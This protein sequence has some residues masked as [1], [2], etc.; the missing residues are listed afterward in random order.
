MLT[1]SGAQ[2]P[3]HLIP[4]N[5]N[6]DNNLAG[7]E[8]GHFPNL[9]REHPDNI[10]CST[11]WELRADRAPMPVSM[12]CFGGG[13]AAVSIDPY[14]EG[15]PID[16]PQSDN[17]IRNGLCAQ[18]GTL[19]GS[20]LESADGCGVTLGYGNL[21]VTFLNKDMWRDG[22]HHLSRGASASG[23][24]FLESA[25]SRQAA[26]RVMRTLY[27]VHREQPKTTLNR[28]DA[29]SALTN[30]FLTVNWHD[31]SGR[32][33]NK[34]C[35]LGSSTFF[36]NSPIRENFTNMQRIGQTDRTLRAWR[37][38][39]EIGWTG[40][41]VI[42]TPLLM[43][44][45]KLQNDEAFKH[46]ICA[47]DWVAD[48]YNPTSGLLWDVCGKHEGRRL[49]WW[50]S[51]YLVK[52]VHCAYTNGSA[53][54]HLLKSYEYLKANGG[55]AP[56]AWLDA[57]IKTLETMHRLQL[58]D[59]NFGYTYSPFKPKMIDRNGFAGAWFVPAMALAYRLTGREEFLR[60]AKLGAE[61][62]RGPVRDLHCCGTPMDT[63][64]SPE[65]EGNLGFCHGAMILHEITG[66]DKYLEML[67]ESAEY[68]Y[69]WRYAFRARPEFP[70]LKGSDWNSCG[71]SITSVSNP[72]IH[73]MGIF[74]SKDLKY[75]A[76][77]SGDDYHERRAEDGLLWSLNCIELYPEVSGYGIRG[78]LTERFC[79]SDGL[80]IE[81]L[82]DGSPSSLWFGYNG[83][84]AAAV[85]EG[86]I[87]TS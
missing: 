67:S 59:G 27:E 25:S 29:V 45:H 64:K 70:P 13:L 81:K 78:V 34:N 41:G 62:Y 80:V 36:N 2:N 4:G 12:L 69:L 32:V 16:Q 23:F 37:S 6:G 86:L 54:Y 77:Q 82:P 83:W 1:L 18:L 66:E 24:I 43:A 19:G 74:I 68:E 51:G 72:H 87:E 61:F 52:D 56:S 48:A 20:A 65:Q 15:A 30:A 9:T 8:P 31:E 63:W 26:H 10:S 73:P 84:A 42:G 47:L 14:S 76:Q 55:D 50:W 40:G 75:L 46:G 38:L 44:G 11:Y 33:E 39:A 35:A 85:L 53:V 3:F 21:P 49:N 79:P 71:G 5:I 57:A 28:M 58:E 17:F 7:A 22:T 60:S